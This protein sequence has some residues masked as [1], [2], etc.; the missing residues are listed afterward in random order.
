MKYIFLFIF[1]ISIFGFNVLSQYDCEKLV[2]EC[3]KL[4]TSGE[5][6]E[7]FISDGQVYSA[8]LDRE[9]A[10]FKTTFYGGTTYRI[11]TTAGV[12]E[13]YVIF[14]IKDLEGNILY[15]NKNYNNAPVWNFNIKNSL[16]VI[17]TLE[18]DSDL[19]ATGCVIMLIGFKS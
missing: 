5:S 19:K 10:E 4:M 1:T 2:T 13:N 6:E 17:I 8:F 11:A 3:E 16:P 12:E 9:K 18:L 14:T 15:S 7:S